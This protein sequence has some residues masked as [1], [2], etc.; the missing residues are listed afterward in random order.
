V[1]PIRKRLLPP[2]TR[3]RDVP[4]EYEPVSWD[5]YMAVWWEEMRVAAKEYELT[6]RQVRKSP[7]LDDIDSEFVSTLSQMRGRAG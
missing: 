3:L 2:G 6:H 4:A 5:D 7:W 1:T